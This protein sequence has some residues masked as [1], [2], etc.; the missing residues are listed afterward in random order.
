MNITVNS[1]DS[2]AD[3]ISVTPPLPPPYLQLTALVSYTILS[4]LTVSSNLLVCL[5]VFFHQRMLTVTI[6][7]IVNL[8]VTDVLVGIFCIPIVLISDYLIS[9]WPFGTVMCKIF[10]ICSI[11]KCN[12]HCLHISRNE[13]RSLC[14]R[15]LSDASENDSK[16][17]SNTDQSS[18]AILDCL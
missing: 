2:S 8:A 7:F 3:F 6:L 12:L 1:C 11:S 5:I 10:F 14:R 9:N 15:R 4:V 17:V 18:L 13:Y 16:T